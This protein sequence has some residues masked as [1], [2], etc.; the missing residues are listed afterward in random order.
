MTSRVG[1]EVS[2]SGR[3]DGTIVGVYVRLYE[4][5]VARSREII[6]GQ[7]VADYDRGGEIVGLEILAPVRIRSLT[8]LVSQPAR[9]PFK[10][11]IE[12]SIPRDFVAG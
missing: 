9:R 11:F 12:D 3:N 7:L 10:R 8:R 1:Y 5:K 6:A 4:R 2:I